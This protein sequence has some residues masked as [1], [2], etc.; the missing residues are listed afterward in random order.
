MMVRMGE[1]G[2]IA[3]A[4]VAM[5]LASCGGTAIIDGGGSGGAGA[6]S[7][8]GGSPVCV[9]PAPVGELTPCGGSYSPAECSMVLCDQA[10]NTWESSCRQTG[11]TCLYNGQLQCSCALQ[12][13]GH[14]CDGRTPAC[15]PA[16][17]PESAY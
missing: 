9:T 10:G 2:W 8:Q 12:G 17:V 11:C 7:N 6:G 3:A 5:T 1:M 4:S 16:P 14:P 15:C 13:E